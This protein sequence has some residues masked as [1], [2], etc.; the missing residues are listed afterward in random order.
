MRKFCTHNLA[1]TDLQS[2]GKDMEFAILISNY[3]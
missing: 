1:S 3:F 2:G